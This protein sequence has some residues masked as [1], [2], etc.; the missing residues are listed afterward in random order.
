M[1]SKLSC[2]P[3]PLST[4]PARRSVGAGL[5]GRL[6]PC[7]KEVAQYYTAVARCDVA[8]QGILAALDESGHADDTVVVFLSDHGMSFPFAKATVY[9]NGTRSPC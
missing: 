3:Q 9:G 1:R 5:P 6:P 8:L 7:R 4:C 2:R